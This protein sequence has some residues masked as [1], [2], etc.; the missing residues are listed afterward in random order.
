[1]ES[2]IRVQILDGAVCILLHANALGKG[3]NQ[4]VLAPALGK[5]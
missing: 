4:F 2:V 5:Y 1:M 3:V